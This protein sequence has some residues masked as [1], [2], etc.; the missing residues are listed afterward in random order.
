[1]K[2]T[3][4]IIFVIFV[5]NNISFCQTV[6][7]T[8][9]FVVVKS[10]NVKINKEKHQLIQGYIE[11][12]ENRNLPF[13]KKIKLPVEIYKSTNPSPKEPVFRL[14]GG[15]GESN[16]PKYISNTDLLKNHDFVFVGYRGVDGSTQLKSKELAK[17]MKGKNHQLLSDESLDHIEQTAANYLREIKQ[18][19][20]DINAYTIMDVIEDLEYAREAIRYEHINLLSGSFG[21]RIALLYSYKHPEKIHRIVMNGANP[22]GHFLWYPD[23]TEEILNQWEILYIAEG[24]GSIKD[25]MKK[26][27]DQMPEKWGIF[28][29]DKDKVK[30]GTFV[31]LFSTQMAVMAFDAYIRAAQKNDY[32][33]LYMIQ[34]AYNLFVPRNTWGDMFQKGFSADFNPDINYRQYL[35]SFDE[36]TLLGA[37]YALLLWGSAGTWSGKSIPESFKL[38]QP[39]HTETLILSGDLDV[40]TPADFA[41]Q[42]LLPSMPFA[43]QKVFRNMSHLD[44]A[45][46]QPLSYQ[47][48]INEF[49]LTGH[50]NFSAFKEATINF[51]PKYRLYH[52]AK[53]I[54]L[55]MALISIVFLY[56]LVIFLRKV[57]Q[58]YK[59]KGY[60]TR[61][62]ER[63]V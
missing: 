22:P 47:A 12:P 37:N 30:S 19:G 28:T 6:N 11:V 57:Y 55:V 49:F 31:F 24:I 60:V 58:R 23:K 21:T 18:K 36:S 56:F 32:S 25:A 52:I 51:K 45:N 9:E 20:I 2:V 40:S 44:V 10:K 50:A 16:I 5:S 43:Q 62:L 35:R 26:A 46:I 3:T 7:D 27:Y 59:S 42:K 1:M 33:G 48:I 34:E 15:P 14:A 17:A 29:L 54:F 39:S 8:P 4:W 41:T 38:L 53:G 13:S 63:Y 61:R